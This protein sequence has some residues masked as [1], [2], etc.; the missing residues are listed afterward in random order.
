MDRGDYLEYAV[1]AL[2]EGARNPTLFLRDLN[3]LYHRRLFVRGYNP[4]GIDVFEEDWDNLVILDACRFD[5]FRAVSDLPGDL[6]SRISRGSHTAE[7]LRGNLQGKVLPDTV[8]VTAS[9]QLAWHRSDLDVDFHRVVDVWRGDGWDEDRQTVPPGEMTDAVIQAAT[10]YPEKR[11]VAH[12]IQ[13]H[14]PF[15]TA[16]GPVATDDIRDPE[17]RVDFWT[18]RFLGDLSLDDDDIWRLYRENLETA[19]PHVEAL[20]EELAGRTV[21]TADHGNM[22]GERSSPIP[23]REW[24]HPIGLYTE[25]LVKVPWLAVDRGSKE[26]TADAVENRP[27][28]VED[29]TV[30]ERLESLGYT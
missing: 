4:A 26:T 11:I 9:P 17:D 27:D 29:A 7:F 8:Y 5:L 15:L 28:R 18:R 14:F 2:R 30:E 1:W 16:D 12:Y 6:S 21:V 10:D 25:E 19:L 24:G 23:I 13:P 3:R 22:V 20:L